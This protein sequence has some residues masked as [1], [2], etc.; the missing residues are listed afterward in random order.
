MMFW[1]YFTDMIYVLASLIGGI[2]AILFVY[3]RRK[4]AR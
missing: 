2:I 4:R 1:E 3:V